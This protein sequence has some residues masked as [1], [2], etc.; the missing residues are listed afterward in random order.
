ML[1]PVCF[2]LPGADGTANVK[3]AFLRVKFPFL[4]DL[5]NAQG[6]FSFIFCLGQFAFGERTACSWNCGVCVWCS[7]T[8]VH[9]CGSQASASAVAPQELFPLVFETGFLTDSGFR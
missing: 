6:G 5:F 3:F 9:M 1:T 4:S 8:C 7:S 2:L